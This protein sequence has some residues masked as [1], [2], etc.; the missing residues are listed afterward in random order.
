[1]PD[2]GSSPDS[3][4]ALERTVTV[5]SADGKHHRQESANKS[6]SAARQNFRIADA[7]AAGVEISILARN[8]RCG[9]NMNK[10]KQKFSASY[11]KDGCTG[12]HPQCK[13]PAQSRKGR[14]RSWRNDRCATR[15]SAPK[16]EMR[17][18]GGRSRSP[19]RNHRSRCEEPDGSARAKF[20]NKGQDFR[21]RPADLSGSADPRPAADR[22]RE[23]WS[24][25]G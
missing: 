18:R 19:G 14:R 6:R 24:R 9:R 1:M 20:A 5:L 8:V 2:W 7:R 15:P 25:A 3:R 10:E 17:S 12:G 22:C 4:C 11:A 13:R 16:P 21:R 23:T